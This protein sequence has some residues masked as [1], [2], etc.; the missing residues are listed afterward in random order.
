MYVQS[1][2]IGSNENIHRLQ[3]CC[4][5]SIAV[6][7]HFRVRDGLRNLTEKTKPSG[8]RNPA[9]ELPHTGFSAKIGSPFFSNEPTSR[10]TQW[11]LIFGVYIARNNAWRFTAA[12]GVPPVYL[13]WANPLFCRF[14]RL[15]ESVSYVESVGLRI[16]TPPAS[17]IITTV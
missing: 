7:E 12:P 2:V 15:A 3:E 9:P 16:P 17:T 1:A 11:T 13:T 14:S 4:E 10:Q 8:V 5:F 6:H